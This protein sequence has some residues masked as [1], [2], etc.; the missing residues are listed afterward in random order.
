MV[1]QAKQSQ[2]RTTTTT[3]KLMDNSLETKRDKREKGVKGERRGLRVRGVTSHESEEESPEHARCTSGSETE[4]DSTYR[5]T[6]FNHFL[7]R[8]FL[9]L[10]F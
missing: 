1:Q 3:T 6:F 4:D 10:Y 5:R 7:K 9:K 8:S 2:A